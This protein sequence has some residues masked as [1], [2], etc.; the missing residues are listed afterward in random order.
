MRTI[1]IS[2]AIANKPGNGGEA[3]VRLNWI[4]GARRLGFRVMFVEQ[5][6]RENCLDAAGA[7]TS[8]RSSANLRYFQEIERKFGLTG[9]AALVYQNGEEV[10]GVG[11]DELF[12]LGQNATAFINISGNLTWEPLFQRLRRR[13]YVDIDPG[14]TQFWHA[15]GNAPSGLASHDYHFTIGEN[16]G[17]SSCP[18]P[19]GTVP[20]KHIHPPVVLAEWPNSPGSSLDRFTTIACW[21][22]GYGR[23]AHPGGF[24]GQKAHEFRKFLTL[25][26]RVEQQFE[27]ALK[28]DPGDDPD[29]QRLQEHGWKLVDPLDVTEDPCRFRRYVQTSAAEFSVA[30]GIYVETGCGWFSDRT[31]VYLASGKPVLVQ[32]T[33]FGRNYPAGKGLLTFAT[34]DE[35]VDGVEKIARNYPEH[36]R[37]A[38]AIAEEF[39]DSDRVLGQLFRE[40]GVET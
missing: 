24:F 12:E 17:L 34:M 29:R 28:I 37:A 36:C 8:F 10:Y 35:A 40:I 6:Q 7:V 27:I 11:P 22:G 25:P 2:G 9:S 33:G 15:A 16:I 19:T 31:A 5:I 20:W 21:R 30:Q 18:V 3:W 38:R 14:Y 1:V 32:D 4:L 23:V 39:F 26:Q 13:V